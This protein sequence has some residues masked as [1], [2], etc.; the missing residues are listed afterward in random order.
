MLARAAVGVHWKG[1]ALPIPRRPDAAMPPEENTDAEFDTVRMHRCLDAGARDELLLAVGVRLER[2]ARRMRRN[3]TSVA[4]FEQTDDVLQ[5]ATV[6]LLR[7]LETIRPENTRAF[8]ALA[9]QQIRRE[10]LDMARRYRRPHESLREMRMALPPGTS[11]SELPERAADRDLEMWIEFHQAVE[12]LPEE[13]REVMNLVFYHGWTQA[14]IAELF[15]VDERTIRRRW[16]AAC[17]R[18]RGEL[19]GNLPR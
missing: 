12:R 5:N 17:N 15:A 19:N 6:R 1:W 3:F 8:F 10:L 14:Q 18:L 7:A 11:E 9:A 2:L 16:K 4:R 13:L